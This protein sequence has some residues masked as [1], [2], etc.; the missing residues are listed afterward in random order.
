MNT[1]TPWQ[2]PPDHPAFAGHFPDAPIFPGVLLLDAVIQT[3]AAGGRTAADGNAAGYEVRS[4][5]FLSPARPGDVLTIHH[6]RLASGL[7]HFEIL[8]DSSRVAVGDIALPAP[9]TTP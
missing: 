6:R 7:I 2:V 9:Q 1:A 4:V 8:R 3:L 5:K